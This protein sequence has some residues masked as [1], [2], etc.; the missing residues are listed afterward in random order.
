MFGL[1]NHHIGVQAD[2]DEAA[3]D[4]QIRVFDVGEH[5]QNGDED[6][7][8][9]DGVVEKLVAGADGLENGVCDK[10]CGDTG[11]SRPNALFRGHA[12]EDR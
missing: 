12:A 10:P 11:S 9:A 4:D 2:A 7:E 5:R 8:E 6:A 1:F 3:D